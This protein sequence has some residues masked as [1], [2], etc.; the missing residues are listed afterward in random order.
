MRSYNVIQIDP[1]VPGRARSAKSFPLVLAHRSDWLLP[2]FICSDSSRPRWLMAS[3]ASL[4][5]WL[6]T[7][8]TSV[9]SPCSADRPSIRSAVSSVRTRRSWTDSPQAGPSN[10]AASGSRRSASSTATESSRHGHQS[11]T[12]IAYHDSLRRAAR[13]PPSRPPS[14][15]A[16]RTTT[17]SA[18]ERS[19]EGEF[20]R[21][22]S[23][24]RRLTRMLT[25]SFA[26]R[27]FQLLA[28]LL[29]S[30]F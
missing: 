11:G 3:R 7:R 13:A 18:G 29:E 27:T 6:N 23:F 16:G 5:P 15:Q 8:L 10:Y 24:A 25:L 30:S 1:L 28:I 2:R 9:A 21:S 26:L 22:E 4:R 17:S 20:I 19:E 12:D 14:Q